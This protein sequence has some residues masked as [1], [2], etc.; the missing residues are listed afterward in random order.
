MFTFPF[1]VSYTHLDVYKRQC[2]HM[3]SYKMYKILLAN[4]PP[5]LLASYVYAVLFDN[6]LFCLHF[7]Q[8]TQVVCLRY[9]LYSLFSPYSHLPLDSFLSIFIF[10]SQSLPLLLCDSSV[11]LIKI[12]DYQIWQVFSTL[13]VRFFFDK[14]SLHQ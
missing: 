9:L 4:T 12:M 7:L 3:C 2:L 14:L 10:L 6:P 11:P 8:S 13:F 1:A 5:F